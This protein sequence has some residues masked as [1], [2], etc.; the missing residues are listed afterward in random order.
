MAPAATASFLTLPGAVGEMQFC[1]NAPEEHTPATLHLASVEIGQYC[2]SGGTLVAHPTS[3]PFPISLLETIKHSFRRGG[4]RALQHLASEQWR[5]QA[6]ISYVDEM[7]VPGRVDA[8]SRETGWAAQPR[9]WAKGSLDHLQIERDTAPLHLIIAY[10]LRMFGEQ[11]VLAFKSCVGI[12]DEARRRVIPMPALRRLVE[13]IYRPFLENL[14]LAIALWIANGDFPSF[15]ELLST[16]RIG[17]AWDQLTYNISLARL[18][19]PSGLS[20]SQGGRGSSGR[21]RAGGGQRGGGSASGITK[22]P[23]R[24]PAAGKGAGS[25]SSAF[26]GKGG[27]GASSRDSNGP[28]PRT[29]NSDT[30]NKDP[31]LRAF[32]S[33]QGR[34]IPPNTPDEKKCCAFHAVWGWCPLDRCTHSHELP[35]WFDR[36][37]FL[38]RHRL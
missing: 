36:E 33:E 30:S 15:P 21:Q 13:T 12:I 9:K 25:R 11:V 23:H 37:A 18:A 17:M 16:Q 5:P 3:D 7:L 14:E 27:A 28:N 34:N 35:K 24:A 22:K 4:H 1:T 8:R 38:A 29:S 26:G 2:L 32:R 10:V 19:P 31:R 6:I 20:G